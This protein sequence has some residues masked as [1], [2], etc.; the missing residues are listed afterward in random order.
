MDGSIV[1]DSIDGGL[2]RC[3]PAVK[4][5]REALRSLSEF[6][7]EETMV[8]WTSL[9]KKHFPLNEIVDQIQSLFLIQKLK[10]SNSVAP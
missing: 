1:V 10:M 9:V 7:N 3:Y 8:I 5:C 6:Q 4:R 2:N